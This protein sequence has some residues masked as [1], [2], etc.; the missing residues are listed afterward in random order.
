MT[1]L[2]NRIVPAP[3]SREAGDRTTAEY[4]TPAM[5]DAF[6]FL[7]RVRCTQQTGARRQEKA[8]GRGSRR[9]ARPR[10]S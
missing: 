2:I 6:G 8:S 4:E 1:W 9:S 10:R 3:E 5:G 7:V